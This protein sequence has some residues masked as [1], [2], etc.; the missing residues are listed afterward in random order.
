MRHFPHHDFIT[1]YLD[2]IFYRRY[3][4]F[5]R[6]D[7]VP[8]AELVAGGMR[9]SASAAAPAYGV[10]TRAWRGILDLHYILRLAISEHISIKPEFV[11]Y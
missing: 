5:R 7:I 2:S 9:P 11:K 3:F 8:V 4:D 6:A 10:A 1:S